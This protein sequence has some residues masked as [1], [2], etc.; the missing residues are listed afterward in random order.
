M[1]TAFPPAD[2]TVE[3]AESPELLA[4]NL[5]VGS[6]IW[7]ASLAFF[8]VAFLFAFFYLRALNSN[9]L[10]RGWPHTHKPHPSLAFGVA[11]LICVLASAAIARASVMLPPGRWRLA[12]TASL[13]LAL[14]AI[15][16][17]AAQFSSLGFGPTDGGYASVFVGWTGLFALMLLGTVY[18]LGTVVADVGRAAGAVAG[19]HAA[20]VEAVS[21]VL[22]VLAAVELAAFVL[23]Y[24]VA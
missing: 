12:A 4:Q 1:D 2:A 6:R 3:G 24:I 17:Q 9:G 10:W 7:A 22:V 11:I 21:F 23:L 15:G 18:W 5:R 13:L 8:F 14:A 20:A 19:L 16:L